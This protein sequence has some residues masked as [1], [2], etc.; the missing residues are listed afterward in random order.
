[1]SEILNER[2]YQVFVSSTFADLQVERQKVLQA[3]LEL[4]AFPAG[5]ELFPSADDD[6]WDF[7][8]S[9][10]DSSDY[11]VIIAGKYGS[12]AKDGISYTE[13]EYSYALQANKPIMAF[14]I[15]E[16]DDLTGKQLEGDPEM[17]QKL[18]RFR[19]QAKSGK[20]VKFF[21]TPEELK[22]AVLMS[23][24]HSFQ[25]KPGEGW[26]RAKNAR[27]IDDLEEVAALQRRVLE[28]QRENE[29][30][31]AATNLDTEMIAQGKDKLIVDLVLKQAKGNKNE[32]IDPPLTSFHSETTWD[33]LFVACF[34]YSS[35]RPSHAL[36][37]Q[38]VIDFL[39]SELLKAHPEVRP[40]EIDNDRL[41][42]FGAEDIEK[43]IDK[44]Q[45]Q[46]LGIGLIEVEEEVRTMEPPFYRQIRSEY[47]K[48]T[49]K[50]S[51][52][53]ALLKGDRRLSTESTG[54]TT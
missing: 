1:M 43:I 41:W 34:A 52:R 29:L 22:S 40:E 13:K 46:F 2:R 15:K 27:R 11:Y 16:L 14:L 47:W 4:R 50:G 30:L 19:E 49:Q 9:E 3:I 38:G 21:S 54:A 45:V 8:K 37:R 6:Q 23:L 31:E 26:V 48:L 24:V 33:R 53:F 32:M 44:L 17:K 42:M 20:L 7:I 35:P 18:L 25:L 12:L 28:L 51:L 36:V 5:M 39:S 10:I